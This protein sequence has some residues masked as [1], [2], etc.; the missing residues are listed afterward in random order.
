MK[1]EEIDAEA[2]GTQV[3]KQRALEADQRA[4][5]QEVMVKQMERLVS[6]DKPANRDARQ[7]AL[8]T[9]QEQ[10]QKERRRAN[11]A[12]GAEGVTV[13][14][15]EVKEQRRAF[16]KQWKA[17]LEGEHKAHS[18]LKK[19]RERVLKITGVN[20]PDEDDIA[21]IEGEIA[22][23]E[24]A[25]LELEEAWKTAKEEITALGPAAAERKS[26]STSKNGE[27]D[28]Q[29]SRRSTRSR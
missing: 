15:N 24:K 6:K 12:K 13:T 22:E 28:S 17:Q 20:A 10:A 21:R 19:E 23:N 3:L 11:R 26:S 7:A 2:M 16:L 5:V 1:Y 29:G 27:A 18:L 25:I 8:E 4:F 9:A 14:T